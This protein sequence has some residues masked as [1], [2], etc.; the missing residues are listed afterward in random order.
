MV[1]APLMM[2]QLPIQLPKPNAS[3]TPPPKDPTVVSVDATGNYFID[4]GRGAGP[5]PYSFTD[6]Q[7]KL[8]AMAKDDPSELVFVKAE[9]KIDYGRVV[10]LISVVGQ[11]GFDKVSLQQQAPDAP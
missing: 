8:R 9:K 7:L 6:L 2:S 4:E 5:L 1:T 10:D 11:S 3:A